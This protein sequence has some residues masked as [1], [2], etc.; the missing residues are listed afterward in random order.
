MNR[1]RVG[2]IVT[3][4]GL[5]ALVYFAGTS[6][7]ITLSILTSGMPRDCVRLSAALVLLFVARNIFR[8]G[9]RL[10]QDSASERKAK[11]A[12]P[13]V[14]L[15]RAFKSDR[16]IAEDN[17]LRQRSLIGILIG[18]ETF[19]E[20]MARILEDLGPTVALGQSRE[21]LPTFGFA[22]DYAD[23]YNWR[24]IFTRY[25]EEAGWVVIILHH[26]TANLTFE[27][28]ESLSF[29]YCAKIL[30]VPPPVRC[31]TESWYR[32]Y[33]S[34]RS[35]N[36]NLP[37]INQDTAAIVFDKVGGKTSIEMQGSHSPAQQI[38]VIHAALVIKYVLQ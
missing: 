10:A 25:L 3:W 32:A 27:I 15:L 24:E 17:W 6:L 14:L 29:K 13:V 9:R 34:V 1:K 19:E 36:A 26:I 35:I 21:I 12:R 2:F 38:A 16:E 8:V 18:R 20:E 23:D 5:V 7:Q 11:D 28:R 33:E 30:L 22:K 31:R 37:L 4:L